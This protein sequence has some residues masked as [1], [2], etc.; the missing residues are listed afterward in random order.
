MI[1][2]G[3]VYQT[4]RNDLLKLVKEGLLTLEKREKLYNFLPV[5]NLRGKLKKR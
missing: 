5:A 1:T 2:H 4:A 3:I